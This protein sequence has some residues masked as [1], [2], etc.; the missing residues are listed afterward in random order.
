MGSG[1]NFPNFPGI[2]NGGKFAVLRLTVLPARRPY[3]THTRGDGEMKCRSQP[4]LDLGPEPAP[5]QAGD[6][7]H[8]RKAETGTRDTAGAAGFDPLKA[9]ENPG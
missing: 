6:L 1:S 4:E 5:V 3:S 9:I 2:R 8:N 7:P